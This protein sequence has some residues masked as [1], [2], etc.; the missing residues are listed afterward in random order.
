MNWDWVF[1]LAFMTGCFYK[2]AVS[3][4]RADD[5]LGLVVSGLLAAAC[6]FVAAVI[7]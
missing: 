7:Q 1:F 3:A 2:D 5:K 6:L 4:Y